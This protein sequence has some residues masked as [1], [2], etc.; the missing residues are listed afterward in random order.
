MVRAEPTAPANNW[1]RTTTKASKS[2]GITPA[3]TKF[4]TAVRQAC[5]PNTV[6]YDAINSCGVRY[7]GPLPGAP[8]HYVTTGGVK[9]VWDVRVD[10]ARDRIM[11]QRPYNATAETE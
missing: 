5:T 8:V 4:S 6:C 1:K 10:S 2:H 7:G 3:P 11:T 9:A